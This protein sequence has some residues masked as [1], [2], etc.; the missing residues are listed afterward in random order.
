M[1]ASGIASVTFSE[2][3]IT[4][5]IRL[6][7]RLF[8]LT[9]SLLQYSG[10]IPSVHTNLPRPVLSSIQFPRLPIASAPSPIPVAA[11]S[12]TAF[13]TLVGFKPST[14][15][16]TNPRPSSSPSTTPSE[17]LYIS[18]KV[19]TSFPWSTRSRTSIPSSTVLT[20]VS[21]D[22]IDSVKPSLNPTLFCT[23]FVVG[24]GFFNGSTELLED[25]IESFKPE[26]NVTLAI[27][28]FPYSLLCVAEYVVYV[29]LDTPVFALV[30]FQTTASPFLKLAF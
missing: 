13:T 16:P 9:F 27:I 28:Y 5:E 4:E 19:S 23:A 3:N 17:S 21:E 22:P 10:M 25:P 14:T 15:S 24:K 29:I 20:E 7:L 11:P 12:A 18:S 1:S 6:S 8:S 30:V 2:V 26:L